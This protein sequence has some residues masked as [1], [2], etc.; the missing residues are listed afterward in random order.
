M[1]ADDYDRLVGEAV[2]RSHSKGAAEGADRPSAECLNPRLRARQD[3]GVDVVGALVG[4]DGLE[5]S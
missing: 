2:I 4:V 5:V 1:W 3:E